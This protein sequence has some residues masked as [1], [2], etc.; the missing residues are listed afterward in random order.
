MPHSDCG[1]GCED[2]GSFVSAAANIPERQEPAC[3]GVD[4]LLH[5]LL[6]HPVAWEDDALFVLFFC[7]RH[8]LRLAPFI[9]GPPVV[10]MVEHLGLVQGQIALLLLIDVAFQSLRLQRFLCAEQ[11]GVARHV[12]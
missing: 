8:V 12:K 4:P 1:D 6:G 11:M 10:E 3:L 7:R 5:L 9:G 2:G